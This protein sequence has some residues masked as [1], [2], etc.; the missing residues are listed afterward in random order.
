METKPW[1]RLYEH[2]VPTTIRYP[3]YPAQQLLHISAAMFPHKAATNL[4]GSE[5]T[6]G[7]LR[8][9]VLRL[10]NALIGMGIKKGDRIGMAMVNCPQFIV[11]YF[12]ILSAGGI[13]VNMNPMY[14]HDELKFMMENTGMT[15]IFTFDGALPVMRPLV[16]EVG[17][18]H[19]I[20]T[21]VSDYMDGSAISSAKKLDLEE[22]WRHFSELLEESN[23]T[24]IPR[25]QFSPDDPALIQ[26]TGG[27]TGLPKGA[28]LTHGNIVSAAFQGSI[29]G[30]SI[31]QFVPHEKR[32]AIAAIPFFHVYGNICCINWSMFNA[33]TLIVLPKF[34]IDEVLG[35]IAHTPEIT[36]FPAVPTMVTAVVN[37]PRA[38]E[39]R[40]G[41]HI[42]LL[43]SGGAP[44]PMELINKVKDM[45]IFFSE[46][47]GMSETTS[48][49]ISNPIMNPKVGSIGIPQIDFDVK[50]VDVD[51][52][53]DEV[54][55]GEP[56][57][58]VIKG[59]SVMKEYWNNPEETAAQ[60]KD[61]WLYTGDIAQT[62]EDGYLYIVDRKKDMIIA[63]GFNIYPREVDEV[64]YQHPKIAEAVAV[65][66]PDAY[67]GETI[68]AFIV[69]KQ[70]QQAT[71]KE[72]IAFCKEK[73]AAYKVPKLIEFRESIPKSNIG[74][75]LRKILREEEIAK[76]S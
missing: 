50:L 23:D 42:H 67:R 45:G 55:P 12:A 41:E 69:L 47:W 73:L 5:L 4:Y 75:I 48:G 74:K 57:E 8:T 13:V 40:I 3:R 25:L 28:V 53:V 39:I 19:V 29:W 32:L 33:G 18:K 58:I 2:N 51:D 22:G 30:E 70:G 63:G 52:G 36:Y 49:G 65:G 35:I 11:A 24:R 26:F 64:L 9:Q 21:K 7:Q 44:M 38:E 27:T 37:H 61:G 10:A 62:D 17:L 56:G 72:V 15:G 76:S 60:L 20:V 43:S 34:D 71:E 1:H 54:K 46:G 6:F 31:N 66:V 68:K 14:T 16:R 59:P